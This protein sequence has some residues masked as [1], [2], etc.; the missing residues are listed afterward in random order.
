MPFS[1]QP[2]LPGPPVLVFVFRTQ[3]SFSFRL[4]CS[5]RTLL[6]QCAKQHT[7]HH[8]LTWICSAACNLST[9]T[10]NVTDYHSVLPPLRWACDLD[11][12]EWSEHNVQTSSFRFQ[13]PS[14]WVACLRA[15]KVS[16]GVVG[17]R[18]IPST[19]GS[20]PVAANLVPTPGPAPLDT[21]GVGLGGSYH[22]R[23]FCAP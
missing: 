10:N 18:S 17:K 13:F 7:Q 1:R 22:L 2:H 8:K 23:S 16:G 5:V 9:A 4:P 19:H 11:H 6:F 20:R 3:G 12:C 15:G 21:Q 14:D